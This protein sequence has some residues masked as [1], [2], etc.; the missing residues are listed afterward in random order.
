MPR[1]PLRKPIWP[2]KC[3]CL[4]CVDPKTERRASRKPPRRSPDQFQSVALEI[5]ELI[6]SGITQTQGGGTIL[7]YL[8]SPRHFRTRTKWTTAHCVVKNHTIDAIVI[9]FREKP[10]PEPIYTFFDVFAWFV[11]KAITKPP[12]ISF[13]SPF[14]CRPSNAAMCSVRTPFLNDCHTPTP[15]TWRRYTVSF[16]YSGFS[17]S[18]IELRRQP[19]V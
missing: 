6:R 8:N 7:P 1:P 3:R 18:L 17:K 13:L 12:K 14:R 4:F 2:V 10:F 15:L 11:L 9:A 5:L 19:S 16:P